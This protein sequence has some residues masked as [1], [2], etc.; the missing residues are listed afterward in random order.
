MREFQILRYLS[1]GKFLIFIIAL[2]GALAVYYYASSEQTYTAVTAIRY[3]NG[4]IEQGLTPNG[5]ELDVS[6]I[7]SSTVISGAI[8]DLGLNCTVDE[9][10]SK[11]KVEPMIPEEEEQKKTV[12][13]R[14]AKRKTARK[15]L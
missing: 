12:K 3:S 4:A 15:M 8:E 5:S 6:E 7:Y 14:G 9:I 11:I 1:K 2:L 13:R 10:R